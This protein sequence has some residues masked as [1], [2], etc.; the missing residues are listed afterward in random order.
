[1]SLWR[2]VLECQVKRDIIRSYEH[3]APWEAA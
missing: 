2:L 1:M 3:V